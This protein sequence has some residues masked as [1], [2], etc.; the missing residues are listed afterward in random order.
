M[1]A[2]L[3]TMTIGE[4]AAMHAVITTTCVLIFS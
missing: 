4:F 3:T 1:D 2:L